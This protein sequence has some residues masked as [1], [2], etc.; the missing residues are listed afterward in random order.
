MSVWRSAF[1]AWRLV[2]GVRR[3]SFSVVAEFEFSAAHFA[4][5]QMT[6]QAS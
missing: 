1:G 2:F 4:R 3:L 6:H 5:V